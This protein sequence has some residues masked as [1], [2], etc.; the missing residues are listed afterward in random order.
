MAVVALSA[1]EFFEWLQDEQQRSL[2]RQVRKEVRSEETEFRQAGCSLPDFQADKPR[3]RSMRPTFVCDGSTRE[4]EPCR[5][6]ASALAV[7][8]DCSSAIA[9]QEG[10]WVH[11]GEISAA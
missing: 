7:R 6:P 10:G 8:F 1:D 2:R 9:T 11:A 4:L 3:L 5:N